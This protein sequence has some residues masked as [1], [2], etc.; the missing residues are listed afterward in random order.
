[1]TSIIKWC[2]PI[3]PLRRCISLRCVFL[4]R[5]VIYFHQL[6]LIYSPIPPAGP[7][8]TQGREGMLRPEFQLCSV[9][10]THVWIHLLAWFC[11]YK[12][13]EMHTSSWLRQILQVFALHYL[14]EQKIT[15]TALS[16]FADLP[17][18]SMIARCFPASSWRR[19]KVPAFTEV[20]MCSLIPTLGVNY[21]CFLPASVRPA[22]KQKRTAAQRTAFIR[23]GVGL[24]H[25]HSLRQIGDVKF[26]KRK[27][28]SFV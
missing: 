12:A 16:T 13:T 6:T 1:M 21:V 10:H 2:C 14:N 8:R 18:S 22:D 15:C 7:S 11:S 19:W 17:R 5:S 24:I 27:Q 28:P 4:I 20:G 25:V 23:A 3:K 9:C 26:K